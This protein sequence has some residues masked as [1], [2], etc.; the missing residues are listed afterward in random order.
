MPFGSIQPVESQTTDRGTLMGIQFEV[1]P[2]IYQRPR[3]DPPEPRHIPEGP[4]KIT[5]RDIITKFVCTFNVD[6]ME[7]VLTVQE[8]IYAETGWHPDRTR[9][10]YGNTQMESAKRLTD[11]G[12]TDSDSLYPYIVMTL[13]KDVM[14]FSPTTHYTKQLSSDGGHIPWFLGEDRWAR[15]GSAWLPGRTTVFNVQIINPAKYQAITGEA[16]QLAPLEARDYVKKNLLF[17]ATYKEPIM[18]HGNSDTGSSTT[19]IKSEDEDVKPPISTVGELPVDRVNH[20]ARIKFEEDEDIKPHVNSI[21]GP[22]VGL[23]NPYGPFREF[24][25]IADIRKE[26]REFL[27][28]KGF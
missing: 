5:V 23:I 12:V 22:P 10:R 13:V 28:L 18:T 25:T 24:R 14:D 2:C 3:P 15:K 27:E 7:H 26:L 20:T 16:P 9:L 6:L 1:T 19:H 11:Y 17:P 4:S 8:R 21:G